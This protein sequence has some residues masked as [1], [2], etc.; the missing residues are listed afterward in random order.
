[1]T[2][3]LRVALL[4]LVP[5]LALVFAN[6]AVVPLAL[7]QV[8]TI[9]VIANTVAAGIWLKGFHDP[10]FDP[11]QFDRARATETL[12]ADVWATPD[13]TDADTAAWTLEYE[14]LGAAARTYNQLA[15]RSTYFSLATLAFLGSAYFTQMNTLFQPFIAAFGIAISFAFTVASEKNVLLRDLHRD[16]Q[17]TLEEAAPYDGVLTSARSL[18]VGLDHGRF[19]ATDLGEQL[20]DF[21]KFWMYVWI[22]AYHAST[23]YVAFE[24]LP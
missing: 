19:P 4:Y 24:L 21:N 11:A 2:P 5:P 6:E 8:A 23:L 20:V 16:R 7:A 10:A 9:G 13:G 15:I 17:R 12:E 18:A 3:P 14:E 1:M 22:L